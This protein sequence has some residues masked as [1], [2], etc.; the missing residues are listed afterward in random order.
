MLKGEKIR[1]NEKEM[2]ELKNKK[3]NVCKIATFVLTGL[4]IILIGLMIAWLLV[5]HSNPTATLI[6]SI[7]C[8]VLILLI[9]AT[10]SVYFVFKKQA[11]R[12]QEDI[13]NE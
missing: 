10:S 5:R 12:L 4:A 11:D 13:D 1:M 9:L 6:L 7:I 8:G 3:L 2:I